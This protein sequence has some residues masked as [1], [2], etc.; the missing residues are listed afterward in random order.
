MT[1]ATRPTKPPVATALM[2]S[3]APIALQ[4]DA[5]GVLGS[6][7]GAALRVCGADAAFAAVRSP[8]GD[9]PVDV[10]LGLGD[11][12]W[13]A[14]RIRASLG[15]GGQ[16]LVDRRPRT[17]AN[18]LEDRSIT[19]DYV[20]IMRREQLRGLVVVC[21]ED[22]TAED[23]SPPALIYV[24]TQATGAPGDRA[25][26]E[27]LH[28]AEMAAVGLAHVARGGVV[29]GP[30]D[31][32]LSAR[33]HDVLRLLNRGASNLEISRELVITLS[34]AKGHVRSILRKLD[35]P[36]RLG[37]VAEARRRGLL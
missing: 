11:P 33:E 21:I 2:T 5:P 27:L 29:A 17:S 25:V 9:Y 37:A 20:P 22:L 24:S 18:Y 10:R 8:A 32:G 7:V 14:V 35:V 34:T 16:V 4:H 6:A 28:V 26:G 31:A 23:A 19:A 13:S 12:G 3:L 30:K 1:D 15:V 36:S